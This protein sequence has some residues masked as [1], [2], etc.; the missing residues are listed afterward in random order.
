MAL[1]HLI[2]ESELKWLFKVTKA[3]SPWSERDLCLLAFFV[4]SPCTILE[5]NKI[6]ISDV[7]SGDM[8]NK[9][10]T[11]RG[12]KDFKGRYRKMHLKTNLSKFLN[13][14]IRSMDNVYENDFLFRTLK[15]DAFAITMVKGKQRADSLKRHIMDLLKESGI[16]QPSSQS[17]IRTFATTANRKGVHISD[18]H[19]LLGNKRLKTTKRLIENDPKTMGLVAADAF[20]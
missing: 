6:T 1:P 20:N 16:E 11:I 14:Y 4:G 19:H 17:G 9:S 2:T 5:L 13:N 8:I 18:I 3:E 12:N 10:F 7:L 15:G